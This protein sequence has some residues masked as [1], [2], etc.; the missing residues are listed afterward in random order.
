[1]SGKDKSCSSGNRNL[2]RQLQHCQPRNV[3]KNAEQEEAYLNKEQ[4]ELVRLS[5]SRLI[6][7]SEDVKL[8]PIVGPAVQAV[9]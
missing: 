2:S 7:R 4:S 1:M 5:R 8:G 9:L 3:Y 6:Y